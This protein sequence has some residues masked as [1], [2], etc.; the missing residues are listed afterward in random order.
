MVFQHLNLLARR[1]D[2]EN[3]ASALELAGMARSQR[4][5]R[6]TDSLDLVDKATS[7]L[8]PETTSHTLAL[9]TDLKIKLGLTV[10]LITHEEGRD[11]ARGLLP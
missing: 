10:L 11:D 3:I 7:A 6:V 8:D 1:S 2:A 5:T 9:I 4:H